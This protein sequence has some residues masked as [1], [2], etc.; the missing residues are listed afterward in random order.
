MTYEMLRIRK[1]ADKSTGRRAVAHD[2]D[3]GESYL[4]DPDT[5]GYDHEPWP[6]VGIKF[7]GDA[8]ELTRVPMKFIDA[9]KAE[10]W[11]RLEGE[12][13]T[14]APGGPPGQPWKVTHT[15]ITGDRVV[16]LTVDGE[17]AYDITHNPG[18]Y[19]DESEPS[20]KRVDHFFELRRVS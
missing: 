16:F 12:K 13:V 4:Y 7:E 5:P 1:L 3:T 6:F 19:D 2:R 14:H 15:F 11:L 9:G 17:V 18:K 8:P 10:G 20:G